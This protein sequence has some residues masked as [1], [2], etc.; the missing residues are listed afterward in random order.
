MN[1][2]TD[3]G[4]SATFRSPDDWR[5][6]LVALDVD[7]TLVAEGDSVS[8]PVVE[9]VRATIAAGAIVV[10]ATGRGVIA[11]R[12]VAEMLDLPEGY[13][14]CSNGAVLIRFHPVNG[15]R[16]AEMELLDV[17]RFDPAPVRPLL[18]RL[19]N[20]LVAVEEVGVGYRVN[21]PFPEGEISGRIRVV[22]YDELFTEPVSRVIVREPGKAPEDLLDVVDRV[23][24][25]E[26]SYFI[27]T[28]AWLDLAPIG[29]SK[30]SAL[31]EVARRS[32]LERTEVLAIG[33]GVN[34]V[35]MLSWAGRGVAMANAREEVREVADAVTK[36]CIEDGV[37][38]ELRRW[39]G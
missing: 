8:A 9:A 38:V 21:A 5:P 15:E 3:G 7:G 4:P 31:A 20:A 17:V 14:V 26:M 22:P 13:L 25:H 2:V 11:T 27:G 16:P 24:V 12:R 34:D 37:A 29:V 33:D 30:A 6:R 32:G 35:E 19:P 39:F 1:A 28:T 18:D 23:G 36:S 10:L